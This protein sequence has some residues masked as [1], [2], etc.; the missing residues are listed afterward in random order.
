MI[1]DPSVEDSGKLNHKD[2]ILE[3]EMMLQWNAQETPYFEFFEIPH[4]HFN[5]TLIGTSIPNL[6][7]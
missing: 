2:A 4:I 1:T 7:T 5:N 3:E 6:G